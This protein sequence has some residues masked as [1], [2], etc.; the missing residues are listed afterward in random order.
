MRYYVIIPAHNEE[1]H[2]S[3]TLDSLTKQTL[4]PAMVV[5]VN[6]HSTD[7]TEEIID[8]YC[9]SHSFFK[10]VN[11]TSDSA[12][13]PGGKVVATF[14]KGLELLDDTYD[15]LVKLDADL[16][17]PDHY[18]EKIAETFSEN[19]HCGIA[20]GF[21]YELENDTWTLNHPMKKDHVRGAFKAYRKNCFTDIGGLRVSIG[22]DTADELLA[23]YY[24]YSIITDPHLRVKHLRPTGKGYNKKAR[25]MQGE[26][27][28]RMRYGFP[29]TLIASIK[30]ALKQKRTSVVADNLRGYFHAMQERKS[31]IVTSKQGRFIRRFRWKG[32]TNQLFSSAKD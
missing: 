9:G 30:M 18:F 11:K 19:P 7:R 3:E 10:K 25:L 20:G 15:F 28:Y 26:A 8:S 21:A 5:I 1:K 27:M 23:R 32:I 31:K 22:W 13:L 6:D 14:N 12:H 2:L 4:P 17:L 24:G 16:I 29:I